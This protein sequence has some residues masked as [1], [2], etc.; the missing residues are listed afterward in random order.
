M[1]SYK[2]VIVELF[3]LYNDTRINKKMK[4]KRPRE[5]SLAA[6]VKNNYDGGF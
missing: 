1:D 6:F 5:V 4:C 3:I 2:K